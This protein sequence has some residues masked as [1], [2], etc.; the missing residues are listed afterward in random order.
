VRRFAC[1][2]RSAASAR[3]CS[4]RGRKLV[5]QQT[6]QQMPESVAN[7][8]SELMGSFERASAPQ[9]RS[10]GVSSEQIG[11]LYGIADRD[12]AAFDHLGIDSAIAVVESALQR[13]GNLQIAD[14]G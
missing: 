14:A 5:P 11:R 12:F 4:R 10:S 7:P 8:F 3:A 1:L 9:R 13:R 6:V 2:E